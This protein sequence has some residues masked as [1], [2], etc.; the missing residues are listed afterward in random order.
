MILV[1]DEAIFDDARVRSADILA[2]LRLGAFRGHGMLVQ[3]QPRPGA[4]PSEPDRVKSWCGGLHGKLCRESTELVNRCRN[5]I[6]AS[7]A[8]RPGARVL[9]S[10]RWEQ[11]QGRVVL[12][13]GEAIRVLSEPLHVLVENALRDA[14]FLRRILPPEWRKK[15]AL[16]EC[17]GRVR[18]E[19]AGGIDEMGEIVAH[20]VDREASKDTWG[21]PPEA[22]SLVHFLVYDHDG[23]SPSQCSASAAKLGKLCARDPLRE[24]HH[25]LERR[26]QEHYL[27]REL[28]DRIARADLPRPHREEML[29]AIGEF[30]ASNR[31]HGTLP[32]VGATDGFWKGRFWRH[33]TEEWLDSWFQA[34]GA[35]DEARRLGEALERS[36]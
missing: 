21:M 1:V 11:R 3:P 10:E 14:E 6:P 17:S 23:P 28:M 19:H 36:L 26:R 33:R 24:R 35:W 5:R 31:C 18:F 8:A 34:D 13:M 9:V 4:K 22:W 29:T 7:D 15:L 16:W 25:M 2:L 32:A 20:M 12:T 27:P 30:F